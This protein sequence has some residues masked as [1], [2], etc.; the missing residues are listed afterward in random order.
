MSKII[1][2]DGPS[3]CAK[4]T[5]AQKISNELGISWIS[6]DA[7]DDIV[8]AYTSIDDIDNLFPKTALRK[9]VVVEMMKCTK[10][11][12]LKKLSRSI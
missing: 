9:K 7:F 11:F 1:L 12:L 5:L 6:S 2:I 4:T 3:R 10:F 8:K